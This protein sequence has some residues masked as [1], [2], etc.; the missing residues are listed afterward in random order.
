MLPLTLSFPPASVVAFSLLILFY[1]LLFPYT[2]CINGLLLTNQHSL[3][4][5]RKTTL[6]HPL[7][8]GGRI[9]F[10]FLPFYA[11]FC[12]SLCRFL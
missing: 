7:F 3:L 11:L 12:S 9:L 6:H 1:L 2:H 5:N 8:S 4:P 10:F